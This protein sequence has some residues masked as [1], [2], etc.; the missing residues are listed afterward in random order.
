VGAEG[1]KGIPSVGIIERLEARLIPD[2]PFR[3][4]DR[5]LESADA[6]DFYARVEDAEDRSTR[7][8]ARGREGERGGAAEGALSALAAYL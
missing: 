5:T 4:L 7:A 1:E 6:R 8:R 2:W 3:S